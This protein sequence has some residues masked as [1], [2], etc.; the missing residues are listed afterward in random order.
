M[1]GTADGVLLRALGEEDGDPECP[2]LCSGM[3][4]AD[5]AKEMGEKTSAPRSA[6]E[7]AKRKVDA[8]TEFVFE[9][10]LLTSDCAVL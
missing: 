7:G 3:I 2:L 1:A 6:R 9:P 5:S 4:L 8:S 10:G